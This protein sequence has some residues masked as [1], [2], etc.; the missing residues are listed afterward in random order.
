M[1]KSLMNRFLINR[2]LM[3]IVLL[4]FVTLLVG[5]GSDSD[6]ETESTVTPNNPY[7]NTV[8]LSVELALLDRFS[9]ATSVFYQGEEIE[10]VLRVSNN[11]DTGV[12]F[13]FDTGQQYDFYVD[14]AFGQVWAWSDN[15]LF[16]A[17]ISQLDIPPR[18][19]V[20]ISEFVDANRFGV[21][22]YT[23]TGAFVNQGLSVSVDFR[24]Q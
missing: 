14:S 9:R 11:T 19:T 4:M 7:R 23:A 12:I 20:S 6:S 10:M 18:S 2:F 24:V 13:D 21:G 8:N 22:N 16:S 17:A 5:C 3:K 15:K 1:G